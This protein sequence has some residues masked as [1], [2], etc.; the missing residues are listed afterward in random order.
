M[1]AKCLGLESSSNLVHY[2][3]LITDSLRANAKLWITPMYERWNIYIQM[4]RMLWNVEDLFN[5]DNSLNSLWDS[6]GT[7]LFRSELFLQ[8]VP[9]RCNVNLKL[10]IL[11]PSK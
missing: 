4:N 9:G 3:L 6:H 8:L 7:K 11:R 1:Y 2:C 5:L 10:N